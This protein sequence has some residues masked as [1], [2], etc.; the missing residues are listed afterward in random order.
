MAAQPQPGQGRRD[1]TVTYA[2]L[3][4]LRDWLYLAPLAAIGIALGVWGFTD[5]T[6]C[7]T[8]D[9]FQ[10]AVKSVG[11]IRPS[12][13]YEHPWQLFIAQ[14]WMPALFLVG[15]AKLVL[16][17]VRRDFR[18]ALAR[19]QSHHAIVCGLGDTG[20]QIVE[21]LRAERE[22]VVAVT[23][24]DTD[25]NAVACERLGVAVLKGDAMQIGMLR[26]AGLLRADTVVIT[27]GS[28]TTNIE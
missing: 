2:G 21:N 10:R 22:H 9:F 3:F 4:R 12:V 15:G 13:G 24:D 25:S 26:L 16:L 18:V 11:L 7:G 27:C 1:R 6:D 17:N 23:L 5:C 20:R 19:R 8:T 28:D 14:F